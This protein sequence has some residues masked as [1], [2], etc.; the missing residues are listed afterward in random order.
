MLTDLNIIQWI[1]I[2]FCAFIFG[3]SKAGVKGIAIVA[4]PL[5]AIAFGGKASTGI[6]LPFFIMGDILAVYYYKKHA[7]WHVL[8]RLLPWVFIGILFGVWFGEDLPEASFKKAMAMIIL[9][10]VFV[11]VWW[12]RQKVKKVPHHWPFKMLMG[13]LV[14]F[15]TMVGNLAGGFANIFFLTMRFDKN[16]F[17]GTAA[18]LFFAGNLFKLPFHIFV[19]E[20]ISWHT[21]QLNFALL[22]VLLLGFVLGIRIVKIINERLFRMLILVMTAIGALILFF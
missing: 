12:D 3:V 6:V 5:M 14:G 19:W 4:I 1:L 22:P 13:L 10:S 18:W 8:I 15:T 7:N 9:S 17:I 16:T 21:A 2:A 20:T 11:M